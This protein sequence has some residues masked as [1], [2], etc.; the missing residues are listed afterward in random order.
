MSG[1][2]RKEP[3][4]APGAINPD[5]TQQNIAS[6]I[7]EP[8]WVAHIRPP[9]R[10][11]NRLKR[12]QMPLYGYPAGTNPK[13]LKEDHREPLELGGAPRDPKNLWP[14]PRDQ[15]RAKDRLETAAKRDVCAGRMTLAE[16]RAI[17]FG[18]FWQDYD[19]R[20]GGR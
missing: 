5:V 4:L 12:A 15:A 6:T 10:F 8:G 17:F 16:A 13:S 9:T 18:D 19:R 14:E 11:T 3:F 2:N 7:C 20:F 1:D